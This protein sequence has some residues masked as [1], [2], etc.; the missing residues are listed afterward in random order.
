MLTRLILLVIIVIIAVAIKRHF[1]EKLN[2]ASQT[3]GNAQKKGAL[4]RPEALAILGLQDPASE[5]EI[6][7][8]Y[9]RLI[10]KVHPDKGGTDFFA[11][12]LNLAKE[13][14]LYGD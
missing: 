14:L 3:N 5:E 1:K 13:V 4:S 12:Q 2:Q 6:L 10:G 8:A 7:L 11:S 9:K